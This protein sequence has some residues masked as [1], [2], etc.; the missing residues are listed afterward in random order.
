MFLYIV[1]QYIIQ[2][3]ACYVSETLNTFLQYIS[4]CLYSFNKYIGILKI[5]ISI[6]KAYVFTYASYP[7]IL[8]F[9][10]PVFSYRILFQYFN[11]IQS[12]TGSQCHT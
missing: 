2:A 1:L 10:Y 3:D 11:I 12:F 8:S 5:Y 7:G 6:K 9:Y 4:A